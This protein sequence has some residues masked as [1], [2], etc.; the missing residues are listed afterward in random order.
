MVTCRGDAWPARDRLIGATRVRSRLHHLVFGE[1][2]DS[3]DA[4]AFRQLSLVALLA[5]IGLGAD[6]LSS[7]AWLRDERADRLIETLCAVPLAWWRT[8]AL[9]TAREPR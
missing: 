4:G 3:E 5:C 1:P 8:A 9:A 6:G 2:R 7:S